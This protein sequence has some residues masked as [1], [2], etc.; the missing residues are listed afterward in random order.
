MSSFKIEKLNGNNYHSWKQKIFHL[1]VLKDLQDHI[2]GQKPQIEDDMPSWRASDAKAQAFIA[3]TLSDQLLENVRDVKTCSEMWTSIRDVFE[4]HTLLNKLSARR[5]FYT[6]SKEE[7]E[8]ILQFSNR[9]RHLG[10][11]LK[12]MNV[13][14]DENEMAM[15]FL[16]GLPDPYDP[17]ISALD[18]VGNEESK[19]DF[20]HVKSRV[21]QEEQRMGMRVAAASS[22]AESAALLAENQ[23]HGEN[24]V[25]CNS[26][27]TCKHCG[28]R[29][30]TEEKCWRKHP[31]LNPHKSKPP[32]SSQPAF[33]LRDEE[34]DTICLLGRHRSG[35]STTNL[36][37]WIIDSGC[38]NHVTFNKS[39]FTTLSSLNSKIEL[40]DGN[41]VDIV[42][43]GTVEL[44]IIVNG[45][46]KSCRL[47]NVF[48]APELGFQL[49]SVSQLDEKG[50][51]TSFSKGTCQIR[52]GNHLMATG[53]SIRKLYIL[54]TSILP[55]TSQKSLVASSLPIWHQRMA[56]VSHSS[57]QSMVENNVIAG[58]HISNSKPDPISCD[59]CVIGKGHRQPIPKSVKFKSTK[60]L[61]LVHSDLNGPLDVPS[62]G[63]SKYFVT[64]VDDFSKWTVVYMIRRKSE[65]FHCFKKYHS[66]AQLHTGNSV[67]LVN[68]IYRSK[69][70][71]AQL[72]ALRTDNGGEYISN[73]F[74][75][76]L[77]SHGI[78]H[79]LTVAYTPQ[80]N[81]VAERMNRTV[82]DLVRSMIHTAGIDKKFWAEALQTAVYVRN[83]VTSRSLPKH[84]TPYHLWHGSMPNLGHLR[85]FGSPC[86]YT[87]PKKKQTKLDPRSRCAIFMGYSHQSKGYK[88][89]DP[90][91][92]KMIVSRDVVFREKQLPDIDHVQVDM[93]DHHVI[94]REGDSKHTIN[95]TVEQPECEATLEET[96]E[97]ETNEVNNNNSFFPWEV[98]K[99]TSGPIEGNISS[100]KSLSK[101]STE[102]RKSGRKTNKPERYH[103]SFMS[104][105]AHSVP[106]SYRK[107]TAS[108]GFGFWK[109]GIDRE[110]SCLLRNSTWDLVKREHGMHVLP[111]KYIF[112]VKNGGP[113]VRLVVLGC[114]QL[115]GIDYNHTFAPVV[116]FT[117]V[118]M[119]L[120]LVAAFDYE[121]EQM[122]VVTAFLNGDL[123]EEIFMQIPEGLRTKDNQDLVCKLNK[124]LYGLKQ[125]PRQ[126]YAKIHDFLVNHLQFDC[127]DFDPCLYIRKTGNHILIIA[128]YVDDLLLIGNSLILIQKLKKS[129]SEKFEMKDLGPARIMLGIQIERDRVNRKLFIS[130]KDYVE[131][132]LQRFGMENSKSVS[133]PMDKNSAK[134]M[135]TS[136]DDP[137]GDV[138]YR[139]IVGC[140]IY[141]V[142]CTRPDIAFAVSKLSSYLENPENCHYMA[143]KRVLRYIAGT[144]TKGILYNGS[145]RINLKGFSDSD[146]AGDFET[147]KSTGGYVFRMCSGAVSW[148]SKKQTC[149]ATSTC[150]AEYMSLCT[151]SKEAV[152]LSRLLA[153]LQGSTS[154]E[155]ISIGVDNI[156][157]MALSENAS[158]TER[159]KHIDVQFHYV[160]ECIDLNRINLVH[161][162]TTEQIADSLTKPLEK[163][164]HEKFTILQGV[165]PSGF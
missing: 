36:H 125:A 135:H 96:S 121:C 5:K 21:M 146:F 131:Y 61:E 117:T 52:N 91:I 103:D 37:E 101:T 14:I 114:K 44:N 74:K 141:L 43:T 69:K 102:P 107:A 23:K 17:L 136:K 2:D 126:W 159:S 124:A 100:P 16:N 98:P 87:V 78:S 18:A 127:N 162:P 31:N 63:G 3:L 163:T 110:H 7:S 38:S 130:Q 99:D 97:S 139:Q 119:L 81:G 82:M 92:R 152:W 71:Q 142:T 104:L 56:H 28:K 149:V 50:L 164:L 20:D 88:L 25:N 35:R 64:F 133:T 151:A 57:I 55:T 39:A 79:Q 45:K 128:L 132:T 32:S 112:R 165:L 148:K 75:E 80:Q 24:C 111:C 6:A 118:R 108:E 109:P 147:R 137:A 145:A 27:P 4:R 30:H 51:T 115:F 157:T 10:S 11:T 48:L 70:T 85:I 60:L 40:A 77:S 129:F 156:G 19:L 1:L 15:A 122:D 9:I 123:E 120:A 13:T 106:N 72:K 84:T 143:A 105:F 158:I 41:S 66:Y 53:S 54:N 116:K 90:E 94:D 153:S 29:G 46:L 22:K 140:L 86:F 113:K 62:L 49:L 155:P 33:Y 83:R 26:R 58:V 138:P 160:R 67:S 161:C 150:E 154:P 59:G 8:S 34:A 47:S 93:D 42:G 65:T 134:L 89:W 144:R 12:S 73:E 95:D 68:V 76:Y